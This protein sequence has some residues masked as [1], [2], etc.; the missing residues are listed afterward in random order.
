MFL[1]HLFA[2]KS[3]KD[4]DDAEVIGILHTLYSMTFTSQGREAV[5]YVL[6]LEHNLRAL[7]PFAENSGHI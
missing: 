4:I 7:I 1:I 2:D 5:V 3:E 6:S